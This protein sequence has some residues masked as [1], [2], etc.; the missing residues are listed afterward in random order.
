MG[1]GRVVDLIRHNLISDRD[2]AASSAVR[3][4]PL[5][6]GGI[7]VDQPIPVDVRVRVGRNVPLTEARMVDAC[8][9][10]RNRRPV[11]ILLDCYV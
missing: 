1:V 5:L 3:S 6:T 2:L 11:G 9:S 7:R 4:R 8:R 10:T